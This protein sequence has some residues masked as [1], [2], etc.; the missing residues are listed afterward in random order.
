MDK[1]QKQP[2]VVLD[3]ISK[4]VK[5][6]A[7]TVHAK[8]LA[9]MGE[10]HAKEIELQTSY[11]QLG[12]LLFRIQAK[13]LWLALGYANWTEYFNFLQE[14][15]DRSKGQLYAY[16]GV[17]KTLKPYV[18]DKDLFEMGI[19]KAS[20]LRKTV[21][22][23]GKAPSSD[24]IKKAVNPAVKI[25]QFRQDLHDEAN[26]TDHNEKGFW[27]DFGG[28]YMSPGEKEEWLKALEIAKGIDP[29][30]SNKLPDHIQRKEAMLRLA[31]EFIG[32]WGMGDQ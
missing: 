10:A 2:Y 8:V 24:I 5:E 22:L 32:T 26:V 6:E 12:T 17:A 11:V 16:I 15:F 4:E 31:R 25:T 21:E 7:H 29:V 13:Q 1:L 19:G 9:L 18:A 23:T 14:K 28:C 30:I 20:E 27:M 3:P